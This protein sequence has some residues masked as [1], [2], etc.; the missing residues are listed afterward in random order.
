VAT[1][2]PER[3]SRRGALR[4]ALAGYLFVSPAL[5]IFLLFL[6]FPVAFA[7][8]LS[9]RQWNGFTPIGEAPFVGLGNF[10]S[11]WPATGSSARRRS[12]P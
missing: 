4:D 7:V 3:V 6:A 8:W 2:V 10:L 11:P 12:T 5:T 1:G 9:F